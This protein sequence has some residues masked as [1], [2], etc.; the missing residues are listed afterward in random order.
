MA[1]AASRSPCSGQSLSLL[2]CGMGVTHAQK[3][4]REPKEDT[5]C[6]AG[7]FNQYDL[8]VTYPSQCCREG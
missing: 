7:V 1:S 2:I 5:M 8:L 3:P 6:C 4:I